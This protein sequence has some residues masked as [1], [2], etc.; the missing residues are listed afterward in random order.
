MRKLYV[1]PPNF[2]QLSEFLAFEGRSN[3][4]EYIK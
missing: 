2:D 3:I 4:S 1:A